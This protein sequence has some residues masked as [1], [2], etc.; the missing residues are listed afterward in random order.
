MLWIQIRIYIGLLDS[1]PGPTKIGKRKEISCF[2]VLDDLF[3]GLKA[4]PVVWT[5]FT[6]AYG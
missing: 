2:V 5:D 6:E 1:D 4:S 3:L